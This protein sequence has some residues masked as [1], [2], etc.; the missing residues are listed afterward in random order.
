LKIYEQLA[1]GIPL[2][3][4]RILSHTQVLDDGIC[5]LADADAKSFAAALTRALT[6]DEA[7]RAVALAAQQRYE[8]CYSR[9]VYEAKLRRVLG[10]VT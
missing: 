4:T 3:A 8:T 7:R 2:V 1:S 9:P 5:F 6:D 10:L